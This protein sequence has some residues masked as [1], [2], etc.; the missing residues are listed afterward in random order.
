M[1]YIHASRH[2]GLYEYQTITGTNKY[3]FVLIRPCPIWWILLLC[4]HN[5]AFTTGRGTIRCLRLFSSYLY[6][7]YIL[8]AVGEMFRTREQPIEE[9][10]KAFWGHI[11]VALPFALLMTLY[12]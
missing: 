3:G 6:V 1:D 12:F 5:V 8:Y 7:F 2:Q 4:S 11:Y 10:A 9:V